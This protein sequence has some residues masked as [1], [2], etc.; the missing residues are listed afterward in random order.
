MPDDGDGGAGRSNEP[1]LQKVPIL[2][3]VFTK[4]ICIQENTNDRGHRVL[5]SQLL[6]ATGCIVRDMGT[7]RFYITYHTIERAAGADGFLLRQFLIRYHI[8][9]VEFLPGADDV[10]VIECQPY[11]VL[12]VLGKVVGSI[13]AKGL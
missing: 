2:W 10:D 1:L 6:S 9:T 4:S 3:Q 13:Y 11:P 5:H 8:L 12:M 7:Q